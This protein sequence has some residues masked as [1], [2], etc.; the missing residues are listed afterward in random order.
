MPDNGKLINVLIGSIDLT[1]SPNRLASVLGS[2]IGLAI[3]DP[4]MHMAGLAHI[5][6]PDS[7][8]QASESL[9]GK[10][11]DRAVPILVRSLLERGANRDRL[12]AKVAG[13]ARMF[14]RIAADG[15]C[16]VGAQNV[17]AVKQALVTARVSILAED[18]GGNR[19][20][21][22]VFDPSSGAFSVDTLNATSAI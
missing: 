19:G 2:C 18:V 21:K 4:E 12:R 11:A 13:G 16:D 10:Y 9:P 5:L 8:G 22:V 3:W 15:T 17:L 6:L 1:R 7:R 20:R 14:S